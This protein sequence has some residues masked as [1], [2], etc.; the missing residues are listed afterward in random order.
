MASSITLKLVSAI[1][2]CIV[3][4][5]SHTEAAMTCGTVVSTLVPCLSYLRGMGSL[6]TMCCNGVRSLNNMA[7]TTP[8]RRI[9]CSC[10]KSTASQ[11]NNINFDNAAALPSECGVNIPY[12]ISLSTDCS[13]VE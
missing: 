1:L 9:T 8:D 5:A 6:T 2:V 4:T 3:M 11:I 7:S 13:T 10:L 12:E